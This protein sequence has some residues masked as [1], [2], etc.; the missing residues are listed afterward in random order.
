[1][2]E[3]V[4]DCPATEDNLLLTSFV[5]AVLSLFLFISDLSCPK[6]SMASYTEL[7]S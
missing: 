5:N 7:E 1:M 6:K 4:D 2:N 3:T